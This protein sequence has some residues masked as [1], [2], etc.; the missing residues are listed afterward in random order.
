MNQQEITKRLGTSESIVQTLAN[1]VAITCRA[2]SSQKTGRPQRLVKRDEI[3]MVR[4]SE[5]KTKLK[6]RQVRSDF[7]VYCEVNVDTVRRVLRKNNL[8]G[9]IT[10]KYRMRRLKWSKENLTCDVGKLQK[11]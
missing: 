4:S 10:L 2:L 11:K 3:Y 7:S 8:N 6:A 1:T 9:R 5:I